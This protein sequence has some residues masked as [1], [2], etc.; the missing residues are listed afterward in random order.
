MPNKPKDFTASAVKLTN[1]IEVE[2]LLKKL[3]AEETTLKALELELSESNGPLVGKIA[4]QKAEVAGLQLAIREA[5]EEHGSYQDQE[6]E[7]YAV[8]YERKTAVYGNLPSFKKNFPKFAELCI[9]EVLDVNA[10]KGQVKGKLITE[11]ELE[12]AKILTYDT[13]YS[14]YVR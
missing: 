11:E 4:G 5:V 1:A 3:A 2:E 7:R 6:N 14:F 13:G 8:K 9:K 12:K 10:L